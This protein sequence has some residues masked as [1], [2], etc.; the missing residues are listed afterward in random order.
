MGLVE[1]HTMARGAN[2]TAAKLWRERLTRWKC[3]GLSI[4]EFCWREEVSPP[5]FYQWRK[6]LQRA[7]NL[8][9]GRGVNSPVFVP[10]EVV[11][12]AV[13]SSMLTRTGAEA[14]LVEVVT[15]RG[16]IVRIGAQVD[17][18][19]LR[20]VLRAVVAETGGC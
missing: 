19:R 9:G 7:P 17:E 14:A 2:R 4:A 6:R 5:S 8:R 20:S 12:S 13:E 1:A 16:V 18:S 15:P 11:D 10:V 3:S